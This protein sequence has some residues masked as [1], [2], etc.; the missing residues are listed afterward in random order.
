MTQTYFW[1]WLLKQAH[2]GLGYLVAVLIL[3]LIGWAI[4]ELLT[5]SSHSDWFDLGMSGF[6]GLVDLQVLL[7]L[8]L[9][10]L[11]PAGARPSIEHPS[12]MILSAAGF[13]IANKLGRTG[14]FVLLILGA[15]FIGRGIMVVI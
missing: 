1:T 9:Y 10:F 14:R 13:H 2:R 11:Y 3:F 15:L 8:F 6:V 12:V 4:Y 5:R 7:G